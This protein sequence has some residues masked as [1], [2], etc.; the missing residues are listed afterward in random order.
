MHTHHVIIL[1][2][3]KVELCS[4]QI[5]LVNWWLGVLWLLLL[6]F[7]EVKKVYSLPQSINKLGCLFVSLLCECLA[8]VVVHLP[9]HVAKVTGV[10]MPCQHF[11]KL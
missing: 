5:H 10:G 11:A 3:H 1:I 4:K 8:Y 7:R 6:D 2:L 9:H